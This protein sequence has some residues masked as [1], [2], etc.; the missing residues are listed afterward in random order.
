MNPKLI[1]LALALVAGCECTTTY[2]VHVLD[3]AEARLRHAIIERDNHIIDL[4]EVGRGLVADY[5]K[6]VAWKAVLGVWLEQT[7]TRSTE[8]AGDVI[9]LS[10]QSAHVQCAAWL[11]HYREEWLPK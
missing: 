8:R 6:S 11:I 7:G 5:G 10:N 9:W 1:L 3:G 4:A 2:R